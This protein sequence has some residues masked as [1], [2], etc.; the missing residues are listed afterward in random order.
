MKL[1]KTMLEKD[2]EFVTIIYGEDISLKQAE[3]ARDMILSLKHP[4]EV[5][6]IN[7]GQPIY[8]FV[9]SIE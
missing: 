3:L 9:I 6:L 8:H 1:V 4:A 2:S 7:G 5:T